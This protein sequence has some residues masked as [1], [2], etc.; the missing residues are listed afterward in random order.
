M[1]QKSMKI[2]G[3]VVTGLL[4]AMV[5]F[6][7]TMQLI[8]HEEVIT[9]FRRLQIDN[10][11]LMRFLGL[12]KVLGAVGLWVPRGRAWAV[13]GFTFLFC[14]AVVAHIGAGDPLQEMVGGVIA[15]CLLGASEWL[16]CKTGKA[17]VAGSTSGQRM[18]A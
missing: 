4:S 10:V 11:L 15:L 12:L 2:A 14:G 18:A 1:N 5:T 7:G 3:Y 8:A 17:S 13:H 16:A 6:G 9:T